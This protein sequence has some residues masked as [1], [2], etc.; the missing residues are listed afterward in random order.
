MEGKPLPIDPSALDIKVLEAGHRKDLEDLEE[1]E[2]LTFGRAAQNMWGLVPM[3]VHGRAFL[4]RLEGEPVAWAILMPDWHER[5]SAYV[6][7]FAVAQKHHQRGIGKTLLAHVLARIA[8]EGFRRIEVTISP[9]NARAVHLLTRA[10]FQ[11]AAVL[12]QWYGES[13]D[14]WLMARELNG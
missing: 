3:V 14:R 9:A 5:T 4:A 12:P 7:S 8:K 11:R 2:L 1:L 6:W 13:E 10:G